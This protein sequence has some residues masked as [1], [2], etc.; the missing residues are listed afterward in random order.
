MA[1]KLRSF[2]SL[3]MKVEVHDDHLLP[4]AP[5]EDW[6]ALVGKEGWFSLTK[7]K[8]IRHR[9]PNSILLGGQN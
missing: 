2:R 3:G 9:R 1:G 8:N 4:D 6:I 5:D 7:D